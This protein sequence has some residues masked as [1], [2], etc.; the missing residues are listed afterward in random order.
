MTTEITL[1][2]ET[3]DELDHQLRGLIEQFYIDDNIDETKAIETFLELSE[4]LDV[5]LDEKVIGAFFQDETAS[6]VARTQGFDSTKP[7]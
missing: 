5:A 1:K 3:Q 4:E 7:E 6:Y 2:F